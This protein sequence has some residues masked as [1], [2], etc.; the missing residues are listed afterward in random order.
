MA[1][2]AYL[3]KKVSVLT[4]DGR[5]MVGKLHSCDGS[6]NLVLQ[7]AVERIIRPLEE[8]VP[9][10]EVPLGLY[11]IRGDSVA[12]VGKVDEEIDSKINWSKYDLRNKGEMLAGYIEYD[13]AMIPTNAAQHA[14]L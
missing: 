13:E 12:V 6:M 9:S 14:E 1:L 8:E 3:N 7:E 10:E 4:I 2:N 11:I 5:T